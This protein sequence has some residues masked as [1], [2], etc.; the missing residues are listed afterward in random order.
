MALLPVS[1]TPV[2][3]RYGQ[4]CIFYVRLNMN[5]SLLAMILKMLY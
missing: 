1:I 5:L 2:S 4:Q 3:N